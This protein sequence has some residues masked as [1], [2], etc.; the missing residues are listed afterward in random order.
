MPS[1]EYGRGF[2]GRVFSEP[3]GLSKLRISWPGF[4]MSV[5]VC[6]CR[7][8]LRVRL[9]HTDWERHSRGISVLQPLGVGLGVASAGSV[10]DHGRCKFTAQSKQSCHL[11]HYILASPT[12]ENPKTS[13]LASGIVTAD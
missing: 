9:T 11:E 4:D 1:Q 5:C 6:V 8:G 10:V 3:K 13:L 7:D 2:P 12:P